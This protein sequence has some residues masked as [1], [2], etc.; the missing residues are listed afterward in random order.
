MQ[1]AVNRGG[2]LFPALLLLAVFAELV[3]PEPDPA[4]ASAPGAVPMHGQDPRTG[5]APLRAGVPPRRPVPSPAAAPPASLVPYLP[6]RR[7]TPMS[8]PGE[9]TATDGPRSSSLHSCPG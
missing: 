4:P 6:A 2:I 8:G 1:A 3:L 9:L 7:R 5:R